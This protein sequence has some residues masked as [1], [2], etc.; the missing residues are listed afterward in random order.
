MVRRSFRQWGQL[1]VGAVLAAVAVGICWSMLGGWVARSAVGLAWAAL[2]AAV[3]WTVFLRP[4]VRLDERGVELR[5]IVR[6]VRVPWAA[7]AGA[8]SS[9]SL[10][11]HTLHGSHASW[12]ISGTASPGRDAL[13]RRGSLGGGA[14]RPDRGPVGPGMPTAGP[15]ASAVTTSVATVTAE[16][17]C[18]GLN[19][20]ALGSSAAAIAAFIERRAAEHGPVGGSTGAV[21]SMGSL[22]SAD[23]LSDAPSAGDAA[24][25]DAAAGDA[26]AGDDAARSGVR[27]QPAWGSIIAL[28]LTT[29]A[30]PLAVLA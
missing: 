23:S 2:L 10:L 14:G 15:A 25:G 30:V 26:A 19:P 28:V 29:I 4:C 9:W 22:G 17:V 24:A 7:V 8:G 13:L 6:D 3:S 5:N 21:G 27:S 11:V 16:G 20:P 1:M 12:A 18:A